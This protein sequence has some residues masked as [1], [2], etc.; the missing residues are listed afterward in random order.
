MFNIIIVNL[1]KFIVF[2]IIKVNLF[3]SQCFKNILKS[4]IGAVI[5]IERIEVKLEL[6]PSKKEQKTEIGEEKDNW[7]YYIKKFW[8]LIF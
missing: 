4:K 8:G 6:S 7:I 2:N 5:Q 1:F 3:K